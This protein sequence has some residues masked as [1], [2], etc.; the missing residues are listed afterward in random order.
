MDLG[1]KPELARTGKGA[2][3]R[4]GRGRKIVSRRKIGGGVPWRAPEPLPRIQS[5]TEA[6]LLVRDHGYMYE[7]GY[8]YYNK[9]VSCCFLPKRSF[10]D[11][12][13]HCTKI[14]VC[15]K[16]GSALY[17]ILKSHCL[18]L[19]IVSFSD[20]SVLPVGVVSSLEGCTACHKVIFFIIRNNYTW[21]SI[22]TEC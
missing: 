20:L 7:Y 6:W 16:S 19:S 18:I 10:Y 21:W 15:S 1:A 3:P 4:G 22:N 2:K 11:Y 9:S 8:G 14:T 12:V 5:Q 13:D 17:Y